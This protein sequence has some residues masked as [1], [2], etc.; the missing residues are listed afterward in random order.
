MVRT[1]GIGEKELG[2]VPAMFTDKTDVD[3][4]LAI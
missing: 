4:Q 3:V 1:A 2:Q